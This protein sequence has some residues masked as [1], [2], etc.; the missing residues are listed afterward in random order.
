MRCDEIQEH[1]IELI[2]AEDGSAPPNAGMFEHIRTCPACREELDQLKRTRKYLQ[3]WE[4]EPP[5][6][7][8][9][10]ARQEAVQPR[11]PIWK[12]LRYAGIAAMAVIGF[13]ALANMQIT[14]NKDG[15]SLSTHLFGR[16]GVERDYYT[17]S[18]I[19]N[20]VKRA[21]DDSEQRMN[22]TSYLMMQKMLDTVEQ[23]RWM[24]LRLV[25]KQ[26]AQN[27]NRN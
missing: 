5:L 3:L 26:N 17:K 27:R 9:K 2:Y 16:H 11:I 18:E 7:S 24:D 15:F 4:D 23:D 12:Y 14:W 21:L 20:L 13:L 6:R 19:R 25:P 1:I 22:E 10:V 8:V